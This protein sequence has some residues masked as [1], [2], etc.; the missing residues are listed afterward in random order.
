MKIGTVRL[1]ALVALL[2]RVDLVVLGVVL[3]LLPAMAVGASVLI[4]AA[5]R[6]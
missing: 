6:I 4:Y 2:A 5:V 3:L 1:P